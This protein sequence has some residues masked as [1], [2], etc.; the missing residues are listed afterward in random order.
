MKFLAELQEKV[1]FITE[2]EGSNKQHYI[3]GLFLEFDSPNRNKRIYRSEM[4]D[5]AVN[6]YIKVNVNDGR[7]WGELDH[8]EGPVINLKNASHR[9]VEMHKIGSN[10]HGKAIVLNTPLGNTVKGL[11]ES[12]GNLGVSSR[13]MGT[14]KQIEEGILEVQKD[15]KILTAADIVSDPSAHGALVKG[16]MERQE[17]FYDDNLGWITEDYKKKIN[18]MSIKEIE[19]KKIRI[20][21]SFLNSIK[22]V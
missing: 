3:S 11:L 20:F 14:L 2:G 22:N 9:I 6:S 1:E 7:G 17:F 15:Y 13:G 4:H 8:P 19:E 12:G 21:E 5:P 18:K 16:I 10:W